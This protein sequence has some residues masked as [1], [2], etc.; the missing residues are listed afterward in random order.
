MVFHVRNCN[1][2][3]PRQPRP[4]ASG[5]RQT[6]R[7]DGHPRQEVNVPRIGERG[8]LRLIDVQHIGVNAPQRVYHC[9]TRN[10]PLDGVYPRRHKEP[11]P[12]DLR[13]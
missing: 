6:S 5:Q 8:Y 4:Q 13:L 7:F 2:L 12:T 10:G 1:I 11:S 9:A 3:C